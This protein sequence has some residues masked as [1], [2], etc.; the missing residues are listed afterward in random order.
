MT[1]GA[2]DPEQA[3]RILARVH[4]DANVTFSEAVEPGELRS[5]VTFI[6]NV[7]VFSGFLILALVALSTKEFGLN[8]WAGWAFDA[9]LLAAILLEDWLVP[10]SPPP[11]NPYHTAALTFF[12]TSH[13][14][15]FVSHRPVFEAAPPGHRI[16]PNLVGRT[17]AAFALAAQHDAAGHPARARHEFHSRSH[18][19]LVNG[20][21]P[22]GIEIATPHPAKLA[23]RRGYREA[24][25]RTFRGIPT[26]SPLHLR[27]LPEPS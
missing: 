16:S 5:K 7:F 12:D 13:L 3:E 6:F 20:D 4:Y 9:F 14:D 26:S 17:S 21:V 8:R 19:V 25:R 10:G 27:P 2:A 1:V 15:R 24:G 22:D 11:A 23:H 18:H